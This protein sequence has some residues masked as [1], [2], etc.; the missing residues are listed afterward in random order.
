M[1]IN[2]EFTGTS[3]LMLNN[4][5]STNP[6]DPIVK[7]MKEITDKRRRSD[8]DIENLLHMKWLASLYYDEKM[9]HFI[10]TSMIW[11]T[12]HQAAQISREGKTVERGLA[13]VEMH[14]P[15]IYD[16]PQD[17]DKMYADGR[18]VDIRDAVPAG[19][20]VTAARVIFPEWK[21]ATVMDYNPDQINLDS[22]KRLADTA[23]VS[24]GIG[25]YRRMFGR[26]DAKIAPAASAKKAA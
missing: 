8:A 6:L 13:I 9:G 5:R 14:T 3:P 12:I 15:I 20:R 7:K 10:P 22:L 19:K 17:P 25:T 16:G 11:R 2:I 1:L 21:V 18:F 23:G 26:F 4:P 24:V